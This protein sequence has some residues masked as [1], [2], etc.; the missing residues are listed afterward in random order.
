ML[1]ALMAALYLSAAITEAGVLNVGF[2]SYSCPQ[3]EAIVKEALNDA[4][5]EDSGIGADLLRM[6]FHDC[7][8]R[9]SSFTLFIDTY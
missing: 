1:L 7:F 5:E 8:V 2:Y 6:H 3:A 9:V 4:L